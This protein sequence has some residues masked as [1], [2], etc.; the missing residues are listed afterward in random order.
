ME[1]T[2]REDGCILGHG[3]RC[4]TRAAGGVL[5][6]VEDLGGFVHR[7]LDVGR[8]DVGEPMVALVFCEFDLTNE[9]SKTLH[10]KQSCIAKKASC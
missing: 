4:Q 7:V 5:V 3:D 2:L 10:F 1:R 9:K 6:V 8:D